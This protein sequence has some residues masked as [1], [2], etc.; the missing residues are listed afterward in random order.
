MCDSLHR[1]GGDI[2]GRGGEAM[3]IFGV[4]PKAFVGGYPHVTFY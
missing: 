1:Q 3:F 2:G 4:F